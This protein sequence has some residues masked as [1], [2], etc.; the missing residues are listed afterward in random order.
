MEE[1]SVVC[2]VCGYIDAASIQPKEKSTKSIILATIAVCLI[3]FAIVLVA[4]VAT[5]V[6]SGNK[7]D[8]EDAIAEATEEPI[9]TEAPTPTPEPTPD[10]REEDYKKAKAFFE[11]KKYE[12]AAAAFK[13]LKDYEDSEEL[14]KKS[15]YQLAKQYYKGYEYEKAEEIFKSL[16]DYKES[17]DYADRCAVQIFIGQVPKIKVKMA[18]GD[19]EG[20]KPIHV[21]WTEIKGADGYELKWLKKNDDSDSDDDGESEEES[22][23]RKLKIKGSFKWLRARVRAYK[24]IGGK[25]YYTA[26]SNIKQIR[27]VTS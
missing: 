11:N 18:K 23:S 27:K 3:V 7:D 24:T 22:T 16:G 25:K 10:P 26:W 19:K 21:T 4:L 5:G 13:K 14:Y 1:G 20:K 17:D 2:P 9:E 12:D 8:G 6:I 15:N